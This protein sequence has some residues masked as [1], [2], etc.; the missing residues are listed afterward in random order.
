[1]TEE[2]PIRA[3]DIMRA[4]CSFNAT[5]PIRIGGGMADEMCNFYIMGYSPQPVPTMMCW[6]GREYPM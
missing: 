1:M 2:V 5:G 6:N 3:G 4:H